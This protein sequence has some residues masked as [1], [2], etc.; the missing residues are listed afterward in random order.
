MIMTLWPPTHDFEFSAEWVHF[1]ASRALLGSAS[2]PEVLVVSD[3]AKQRL[4]RERH[5]AARL[6]EYYKKYR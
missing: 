6:E 4:E 5:L 2:L 3:E 1:Y